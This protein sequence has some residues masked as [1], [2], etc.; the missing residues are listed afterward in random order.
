MLSISLTP[1]QYVTIGEDIVVK[2]SR[3]EGGR[4]ILA[5]EADRSIPIV[6]STLRER[7]GTPPP[8]CI[9]SQPPKKKF[10]PAF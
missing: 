2:V 4:C 8:K 6:R 9:A 10:R 5:I 1:E 7:A 3:M